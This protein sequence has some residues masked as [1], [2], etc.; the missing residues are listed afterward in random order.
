MSGYLSGHFKGFT[1]ATY[2]NRVALANLF[3]VT[4]AAGVGVLV[5]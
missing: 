4:L 5:L 2:A 1:P 3:G